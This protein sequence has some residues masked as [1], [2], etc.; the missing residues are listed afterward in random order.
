MFL[1][2]SCCGS[3]SQEEKAIEGKWHKHSEK[4]KNWNSFHFVKHEVLFGQKVFFL[5]Y[6][7]ST[8][9]TVT[10]HKC[11]LKKNLH[12]SCYKQLNLYKAGFELAKVVI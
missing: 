2:N 10:K 4:N 9:N 7:V 12:T 11:V 1:D 8:H 5:R 6:H 3:T